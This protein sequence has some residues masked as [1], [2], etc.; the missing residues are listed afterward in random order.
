MPTNVVPHS[1]PKSI[2]AGIPIPVA[3]A[4]KPPIQEAIPIASDVRLSAKLKSVSKLLR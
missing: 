4:A 2:A 1:T 3:A